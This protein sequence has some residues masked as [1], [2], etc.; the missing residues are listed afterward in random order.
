MTYSSLYFQSLLESLIHIKWWIGVFF[1]KILHSFFPSWVKCTFFLPH[2][3]WA[4]QYF[5]PNQWN[6]NRHDVNRGIKCAGI[7][8]LV[9]L[10]SYNPLEPVVQGKWGTHGAKLSQNQRFN[11]SSANL[12]I[13]EQEINACCFKSLGF[14]VVHYAVLLQEQLMNTGTKMFENIH[15]WVIQSQIGWFHGLNVCV[16]QIFV[17]WNEPLKMIIWEGGAF[18]RCSVIRVEPS[19]VR[20]MLCIRDPTEITSPFHM[21]GHSEKV[22]TMNGK[23]ALIKMSPCWYFDLGLTTSRTVRDKCL[24]L[25]SLWYFVIGAQTD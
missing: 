23:R 5:F 25:S 11:P 8:C 21:W 15:G 6:V 7:A 16:F 18:G 10:C 14:K 13:C 2:W 9:S 3:L 20:L 1:S 4:W 12:K 24:L 17:C 19:W 22:L